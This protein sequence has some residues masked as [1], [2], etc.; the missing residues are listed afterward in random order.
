MQT[1]DETET[2]N[3]KQQLKLVREALLDAYDKSMRENNVL[4]AKGYLDDAG[5]IARLIKTMRSV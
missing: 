2:V 5:A 1:L 3:F 4:E